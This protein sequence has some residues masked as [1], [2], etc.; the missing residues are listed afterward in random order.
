MTS[1]ESMGSVVHVLQV[2][3]DRPVL[4]RLEREVAAWNAAH[5]GRPG[6]RSDVLRELLVEALDRRETAKALERG[7]AGR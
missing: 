1:P 4:E 6:S 7:E 5:P 3:V 2:R